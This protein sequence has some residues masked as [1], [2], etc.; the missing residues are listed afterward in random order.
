MSLTHWQLPA[1][2]RLALWLF[3]GLVALMCLD[4]LTGWLAAISTRTVASKLSREG[5]A[6][7]AISLVTIL[8][9]AIVNA[10]APA[11]L[12]EI[13]ATVPVIAGL[14]VSEF[15]SILENAARAGALTALLAMFLQQQAQRGVSNAA[16]R[17]RPDPGNP[18]AV[19]VAGVPAAR[20]PSRPGE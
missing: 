5:I 19:G 17:P 14:L 6:R 9:L 15:I 10:V 12:N 7:K 4:V 11:P 16:V 13:P 1:D 2:Q 18:G 8:A 3:G 20:P